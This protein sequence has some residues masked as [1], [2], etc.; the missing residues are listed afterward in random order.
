LTQFGCPVQ[1]CRTEVPD[2]GG[3][4]AHRESVRHDRIE[5]LT[6]YLAA[7]TNWS[8]FLGFDFIVSHN[9]HEPYL[10]DAN[11]RANPGTNLGYMAGV[12][13]T[14]IAMQLARGG[15]PETAIARPGVRTHSVLLDIAWLL[16]RLLPVESPAAV[17]RCSALRCTASHRSVQPAR[18]SP[19]TRCPLLAPSAI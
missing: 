1:S 13:W 6:E 14:E 4:S 16:E 2:N 15:Q 7:K 12:N 5:Q 11:P 9:T 17:Q 8:G 19:D 3:T 10:I 18:S